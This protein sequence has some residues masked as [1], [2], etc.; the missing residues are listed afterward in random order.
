MDDRE[1][2]KDPS[3]EHGIRIEE[4]IAE[5][6]DGTNRLRDPVSSCRACGWPGVPIVMLIQYSDRPG[7]CVS[8]E[9]NCRLDRVSFEPS[10]VPLGVTCGFQRSAMTTRCAET[11]SAEQARRARVSIILALSFSY[12]MGADLVSAGAGRCRSKGL[13][14][15]VCSKLCGSAYVT[16][17]DGSRWMLPRTGE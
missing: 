7:F 2:S 13:V 6:V 1:L 11:S 4:Q 5:P 10:I 8:T 9:L 17:E 16:V 12:V 14:S 3:T 15:V